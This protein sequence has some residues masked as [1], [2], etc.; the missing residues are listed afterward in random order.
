MQACPLQNKGIVIAFGTFHHKEESI[1]PSGPLWALA[2]KDHTWYSF[3]LYTRWHKKLL[4]SGDHTKKSSIICLYRS[5]NSIASCA[6]WPS[7]TYDTKSKS[8]E[9]RPCV[10]FL[11]SPVRKSKTDS[12]YHNKLCHLWCQII[13]L[14][15]KDAGMLLGLEKWL[16]MRFKVIM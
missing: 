9:K 1:M 2:S 8:D 4:T 3:E 11:R 13:Y 6:I 16:Q 15:K 10:E 5:T 7:R 14:I 12:W